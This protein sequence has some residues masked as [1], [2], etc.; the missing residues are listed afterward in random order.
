MTSNLRPIVSSTSVTD[1]PSADVPQRTRHVGSVTAVHP[2]GCALA[3]GRAEDGDDDDGPA[4]G[5]LL[6]PHAAR[7]PASTPA[8]ARLTQR[9]AR[10]LAAAAF[11]T[12]GTS[13]A[14]SLIEQVQHIRRALAVHLAGEQVGARRGLFHVSNVQ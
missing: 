5:L 13:G 6:P 9:R 12:T 8:A 7:T 14:R 10:D 1:P 2:R 3:D 11:V 4:V